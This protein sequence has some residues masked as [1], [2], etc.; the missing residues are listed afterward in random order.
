MRKYTLLFALIGAVICF[1][2]YT[3][4]D[5][6]NMLLFSFSIPLWFIPIFSDVRDVDPF[7]VYFLT[8]ITWALIG[9]IL[10]RLIQRTRERHT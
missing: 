8:V 10:D 1:L 7:F 6:K 5:T 3:G 4:A 2:H 9:Y